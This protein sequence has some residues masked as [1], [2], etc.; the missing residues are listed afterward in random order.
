ME[1]LGV[2]IIGRNEGSRLQRCIKSIV[3]SGAAIVYVDSG[4]TDD[5]V[6]FAK[7]SNVGVVELDTSIPFSAGRAR[8]EGFFHLLDSFPDV[9]FVQFVDGDCE[10][11][12]DWLIY[13]LSWLE[14]NS[15][16]AVVCGRRKE[17]Y[18]DQS[19]Y[20]FLC[21]IEWDTPVGVAK[22]SGGDFLARADSIAAV[23]GFNPTIVAGEEP[24][25]CYRLR[26]KGWVIE[27]LDHE[28]TLHDAMIFTFPQ[29][30][31]RTL[32]SGHAYAHNMVLHW[33]DEERFN[34]RNIASIVLWGACGPVVAL[35]GVIVF[36]PAIV[37]LLLVYGLMISKI[38]RYC[39]YRRYFSSEG[40][41]IYAAFTLLGKIPQFFGVIKFLYYWVNDKSF[42]IIEY[43]N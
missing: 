9:Q 31:R 4:S 38:Y 20:N 27:R 25:L 23:S 42:K 40:S 29:W 41:I 18:P 32:R 3:N 6:E 7:A 5:S 12:T 39:R 22:S 21:D 37:L 36:P 10:L 30:W 24:D 2:V 17:R 16:T 19:I 11:D 43:K 8:N 34:Q 35:W 15:K 1:N 13:A 26:Q 33:G 14:K 28:M